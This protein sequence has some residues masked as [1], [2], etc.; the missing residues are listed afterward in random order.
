L[1]D[2][3]RKQEYNSITRSS[4]NKNKYK[5]KNIKKTIMTKLNKI[6]YIEIAIMLAGGICL[7]DMTMDYIAK[8]I[9]P[10]PEMPIIEQREQDKTIAEHICLATNGENCDVLV[11]LAMCESRLNPEAIGVNTNRTVDMG[12]FQINSVH[13]DISPLEKLDVYAS[14]RWAN[15]KI[16]SGQGSIWVCWDRI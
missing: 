11:N 13:K 8:K 1:F 7:A 10:I 12:L 4:K 6:L 14:A 5:N 2:K 9:Y 15:E 16:K 3:I